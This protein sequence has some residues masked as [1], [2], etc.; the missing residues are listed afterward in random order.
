[1]K[2][3]Y[4]PSDSFGDMEQLCPDGLPTMVSFPSLYPERGSFDL[5]LSGGPESLWFITAPAV[6]SAL[7]ICHV[8][9]EG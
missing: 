8:W 7:T 6:A 4:L 5:L 9:N 1:M 2:S 3:K